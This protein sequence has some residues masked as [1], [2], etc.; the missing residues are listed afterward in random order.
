M[1][2]PS[3]LIDKPTDLPDNI[4]QARHID[5]YFGIWALCEDHL[6]GLRATASAYLLSMQLGT[7]DKISMSQETDGVIVDEDGIAVISLD[8]TLMKQASSMAGGTSTVI[9]RRQIKA[10]LADNRTRGILL[11][12]DSPGGTVSGAFELADEIAAASERVPVHA[13]VS[14]LAGSAAYL[15]ASQASMITAS[16]TSLVGSIGVFTVITDLSKQAEDEGI[17]VHVVKFGDMKGAGTPGTKVTEDMLAEIQ[18]RVDSFGKLFVAAV[19]SGR[20]VSAA[21]VEGLADGRVHVAAEAIDLK[22][23]DQVGTEE[24]ARAR[25]LAAINSISQEGGA[26]MSDVAQEPRAATLAELKASLPGA[27]ATFL[28]DCATEEV[29]LQEALTRY[30]SFQSDR[31]DQL[32]KEKEDAESR[33]EKAIATPVVPATHPLS[34]DAHEDERTAL[35]AAEAYRQ[36]VEA[37]DELVD[38]KGSNRLDA[39]K[40]IANRRPDLLDAIN[41]TRPQSLKAVFGI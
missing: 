10:A 6:A 41:P 17:E 26:N 29:T 11:S 4:S 37:I 23:I 13:H 33:A 9:A 40:V 15:Q 8:G 3:P 36:Y 16:R 30:I 34:N 19:A 1:P 38:A 20:N 5:Q 35:S 18:Q 24:D 32:E 14:G 2:K 7:L 22:L 39:A 25:L 12:I 21:V 31:N 28:V 27:P